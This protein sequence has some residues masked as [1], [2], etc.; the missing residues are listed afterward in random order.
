M[1]R[2][3]ARGLGRRR[4]FVV[5]SPA[6]FVA[7]R[8]DEARPD[9]ATA[10][11]LG[12]ALPSQ[13]AR[14]SPIL[15]VPVRLPALEEEATKWLMKPLETLPDLVPAAPQVRLADEEAR[16]RADVPPSKELPSRVLI[17]TVLEVVARSGRPSTEGV[18]G[19]NEPEEGLRA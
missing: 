10:A 11:V 1:A 4:P 9:D 6:A 16:L 18:R 8:L 15:D 3:E 7:A 14:P 13:V 19:A 5:A 17:T 2:A 12:L